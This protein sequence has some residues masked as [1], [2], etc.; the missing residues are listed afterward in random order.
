MG[1]LI[2]FVHTSL[3]LMLSLERSTLTGWSRATDFYRRRAFRIY[4]LA[5]L[6]VTISF[7]ING[8]RIWTVREYLTNLTLTFNLTYDRP[9]VGALWTLP[10]EVQ[11][12]V[13]LPLAFVLLRGRSWTRALLAWLIVLPFALAQPY[14]SGRL[15][16][17]EYAPCFIG[18]IV[19]W[20]LAA[21]A[22]PRWSGAWWPAMFVAVWTIW[23]NA[24]RE[25][26]QWYRWTFCL[27]LGCAIPWFRELEWQPL[28]RP[29]HAVAK[30]S[31]GIYL[32]HIAVL[33]MLV[34]LSISLWLKVPVIVMAATAV[35]VLAFHLVEE[36]FIRLGKRSWARA[37]VPR[38]AVLDAAH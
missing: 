37:L 26:H 31:Y 20:R 7:A 12:Y 16:V 23:L 30:Y 4:P 33:T 8:G 34:P 10:L 27:A 35:P 15:N 2:F 29:A 25:H 5:A 18:G 24:S 14:V 32:S 22:Q 13:V 3:V 36:P 6:F 19:A 28:A 21:R 17:L 9:M 11:M 1:V 38:R